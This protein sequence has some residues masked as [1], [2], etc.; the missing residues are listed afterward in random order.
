[1]THLTR[2]NFFSPTCET[3]LASSTKKHGILS[4]SSK[5][6]FPPRGFH[7][8][9]L[10]PVSESP[11]SI[12]FYRQ[13]LTHSTE[14][15]GRIQEEGKGGRQIFQFIK[16]KP[17]T[18]KLFFSAPY[19]IPLPASDSYSKQLHTPI[20]GLRMYVEKSMTSLRTLLALVGCVM[21][22]FVLCQAHALIAV[23][24]VPAG[25]GVQARGREALV[26][27]LLTVE[28]MVAWGTERKVCSQTGTIYMHTGPAYRE[29]GGCSLESK[30][31]IDATE[32]TGS[33]GV[34]W[35]VDF[36]EGYEES[37]LITLC[38]AQL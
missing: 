20:R 19:I 27:F 33:L 8:C 36:Q 21:L 26:V 37:I 25:G 28:A 35:N 2:V 18:S 6:C 32:G 7:G 15:R 4:S 23:D 13:R 10:W 16:R 22:T 30:A 3:P 12:I 11:L 5:H 38:H 31:Q 17:E 29:G 14:K 9:V 24:K 1:M 34:C